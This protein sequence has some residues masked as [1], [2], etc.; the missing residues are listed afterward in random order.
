MGYPWQSM[1]LSFSSCD[2]DKNELVAGIVDDEV[3]VDDQYEE[4]GQG[5]NERKHF[6][7]FWQSL[8]LNK[9]GTILF[10]MVDICFF[11]ILNSKRRHSL[12]IFGWLENYDDTV[13]HPFG[14]VHK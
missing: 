2:A 8:W 3:Q 1:S 6:S 7:P 4:E 10:S 13:K 14:A 9:S 11:L 12:T 5:Q